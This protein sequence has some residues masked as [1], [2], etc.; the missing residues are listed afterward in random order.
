MKAFSGN[1]PLGERL[2]ESI[3]QKAKNRG[4]R[5]DFA[6]RRYMQERLAYRLNEGW[7]WH[8]L[9]FKG[10][11]ADYVR[12]PAGARPTPDLD[13][14]LPS[15]PDDID[16]VLK[17]FLQKTFYDD[18]G[19]VQDGFRVDEVRC[20]DSHRHLDEPGVKLFVYCGSTR[21]KVDFAF[22]GSRPEEMDVGVLQSMVPGL[23]PLYLNLQP[24]ARKLAEKLHAMAEFGAEN[25]RVKDAWDLVRHIGSVDPHQ[26]AREARRVFDDRG[27]EI[28]PNLA[29]L[30]A[31]WASKNEAAW[32][33]WHADQSL[34]QERTLGEAI[35]LVRPYAQRALVTARRLRE[36]ENYLRLVPPAA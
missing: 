34:R 19:E 28:D 27:R 21:L 14:W 2:H 4:E 6:L 24:V 22:G 3:R 1:R 9:L 15:R 33:Q 8:G 26:L 20:M 7:G 18:Q 13:V 31:A 11:F 35:D 25:T 17:E 16:L 5:P 10:S 36:P 30:T 29:C 12:D 23:E 32:T